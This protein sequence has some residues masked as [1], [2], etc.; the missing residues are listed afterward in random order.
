MTDPTPT[1]DVIEPQPRDGGQR[2]H[3]PAANTRVSSYLITTDREF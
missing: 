2:G 3:D 1:S